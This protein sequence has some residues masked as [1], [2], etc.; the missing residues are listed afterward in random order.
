[1]QH[2]IKNIRFLCLRF[3]VALLLAISW[4][5]ALAGYEVT[6]IP[7]DHLPDGTPG[8]GAGIRGSLDMYVG[9]ERDSDFV[10]LYLYEGRWIFAE[11]TSA[12]VHLLDD[13]IFSLDLLVRYRFNTLDPA[14]YGE[15]A[16]GLS[17]RHQTLDGGISGGV[18]TPFGH[19]KVEWVT[20]LQDNHNGNELDISYRYP[21]KWGNFSLSPFITFSFADADLTNYYFGVTEE[22]S[23]ATG[24]PEYA[25]GD[26][27]NFSFGV[28]SSWQATDHIFVFGNLGYLVL[29]SK[30]QDSP[31][32]SEDVDGVAY[33][34]AGYFFGSVK[35]SKYVIEDRQGEWSWRLNYGYT[36]KHN[37]VPEPMQGS[38][39]EH[40]KVQT[41]I[42]GITVGK[43]LQS[44]PRI[45][46]Y[47]KF[48]LFRHIE[49][50]YQDDF[51]NYTAYVIAIGKG[52]F[53]WSDRPA[54]RW[55]FGLGASYAQ[56]VPYI[57][58][59][60]QG[61]RDRNTSKFLNYLEWMVDFPIDGIIKSKL[62]RNCFVGVTVVHRSGI[63]STSDIL[64]QVAGGADWYTAHIECLR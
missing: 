59:V 8:L 21:F 22:E 27:H 56:K 51:W 39:A 34:G 40:D 61:D 15:I 5:P 29:D 48:A 1:M 42:F 49:D 33:V 57:E 47:G 18:K 55:G 9:Q 3:L 38:L 46:I 10:P 35:K 36:G 54:F 7:M 32:V 12:G 23:G 64:G 28:T 6:R 20:D 50:P 24:I 60:K 45:D 37:I 11:G 13:D 25:P 63:F 44:S 58:V 30:I 14:D 4:N 19:V 2:V 17:K 62:V 16:D 53:P 43:L 52:Y 41:N 26:T 31:L